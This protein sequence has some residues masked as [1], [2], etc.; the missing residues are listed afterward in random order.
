MVSLAAAVL[1]VGRSER[2]GGRAPLRPGRA[3]P[4]VTGCVARSKSL[5]RLG[6]LTLERSRRRNTGRRVEAAP[7]VEI[8]QISHEELCP[9]RRLRRSGVLGSPAFPFEGHRR[10]RST[11]TASRI[12]PPGAQGASARATKVRRIRQASSCIVVHGDPTIEIAAK[13]TFGASHGTRALGHGSAWASRRSAGSNRADDRIEA[14]RHGREKVG[15]VASDLC[16]AP[17]RACERPI[18]R[19]ARRRSH[20]EARSVVIR[21]PLRSSWKR[22]SGRHPAAGYAFAELSELQRARVSIASMRICVLGAAGAMAEVVLKDLEVFAPEAEV[23]AADFRA[24]SLRRRRTRVSPRS[25]CATRRRRRTSSPA[26][27]RCSTASPTTGT[28][29]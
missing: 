15:A 25:T 23:T 11:A 29:R 28:C 17:E 9:T 13:L 4:G 27:T 2:G 24:S 5:E 21:R 20:G 22:N 10:R 8:A 26:M 1:C 18:V 16:A 6:R 3:L 7:K 14:L 19:R 12:A